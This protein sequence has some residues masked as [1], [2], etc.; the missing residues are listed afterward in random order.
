MLIVDTQDRYW[1]ARQYAAASTLVTFAIAFLAPNSLNAQAVE[2]AGS[3]SW[4]FVGAMAALSLAALIE[5]AIAAFVPGRRCEFLRD[6]RHTLFMGIAI[7]Q[8]CTGY[9]VL[10][11]AP[12]SAWLLLR[13]SLDAS[14]ATGIAFF[15]LFARHQSATSS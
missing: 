15:D 5:A 12:D 10:S 6:R 3:G 11:Y 4:L 7:G 8:L 1:L 13:F 2:A 14:V 9:L